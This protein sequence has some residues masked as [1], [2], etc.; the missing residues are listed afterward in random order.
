MK[1]TLSIIMAI[2]MCFSSLA[3]ASTT[4][5]AADANVATINFTGYESGYQ[6]AV[7]LNSINAVRAQNG[8]GA[9]VADRTLTDVA[10][11]RAKEL[12][13]YFDVNETLPTG[14]SISAYVPNYDNRYITSM[15]SWSYNAVPTAADIESALADL[16]ST[17]AGPYQSVGIGVYTY[18]SRTVFYAIISAYPSYDP[19]QNFADGSTTATV[20]SSVSNLGLRLGYNVEAKYLRLRTNVTAYTNGLAWDGIDVS[21]QFT[22]KSSNNKV[23]KAKNNIIY[24]KKNGKITLTAV[25]NANNAVSASTSVDLSKALDFSAKIKKV[26]VSKPKKKTLKAKWSATV[27]DASGYEL[28]YSTSKSFSKSKTKT[29]TLKGKKSTSKTIKNLKSNKYYY[30]RVRAYVNQG[31]GEKCYTYYSKVTKVKVK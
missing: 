21:N 12:F 5:Y 28:Q 25:N 10:R 11:Q 14:Q 2:V 24:L 23:A 1:K 3:V 9:L 26:S 19:C 18:N 27:G 31:N 6:S 4:A 22:V 30:V 7:A 20:T 8:Y 29:V 17:A 15:Y 16:K 13:V